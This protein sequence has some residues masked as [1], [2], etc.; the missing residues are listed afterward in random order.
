M[1]S[2]TGSVWQSCSQQPARMLSSGSRH[3]LSA[4]HQAG[5]AGDSLKTGRQCLREQGLGK[6]RRHVLELSRREVGFPRDRRMLSLRGV[7]LALLPGACN[8]LLSALENCGP[9]WR[10]LPRIRIYKLRRRRRAFTSHPSSSCPMHCGQKV[11]RTPNQL[12][13]RTVYP[14]P[15]MD[16]GTQTMWRPPHKMSP[17][18]ITETLSGGENPP[19]GNLSIQ[20]RAAARKCGRAQRLW[21]E[22]WGNY[23]LRPYWVASSP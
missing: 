2:G 3:R 15:D 8:E 7:S 17:V 18:R 10:H 4:R 6:V 22:L 12:G 16:N 23:S 14:S 11:Q 20:R 1:R 9:G 5:W 19:F 21:D 13:A